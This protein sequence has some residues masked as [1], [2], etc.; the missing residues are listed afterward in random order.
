MLALSAQEILVFSGALRQA[1]HDKLYERTTGLPTKVWF[2]NDV[3]YGSL[4][5]LSELFHH[6][7]RNG[8]QFVHRD[9]YLVRSLWMCG[10]YGSVSM[11][12]PHISELDRGV[13]RL[14]RE[15]ADASGQLETLLAAVGVRDGDITD[16][17]VQPD[18]LFLVLEAAAG[19]WGVRLRDMKSVLTIEPEG[20]VGTEIGK[21][22]GF[23][24]FC[25]VI[26]DERD[27][28]PISGRSLVDAAAMAKF[29]QLVRQWNVNQNSS[30]HRFYS[31]TRDLQ[32]LLHR[33]TSAIHFL[34]RPVVV[35]LGYR[36]MSIDLAPALCSSEYMIVRAVFPSLS[37]EPRGVKEIVPPVADVDVE[38]IKA[39][40]DEIEPVIGELSKPD[41]L[42]R[43]LKE[44]DKVRIGKLSGAQ[45]LG[46]LRAVVTC[47]SIWRSAVSPAKQ[48][49]EDVY[50]RLRQPEQLA[51]VEKASS[52]LQS[53][54]PNRVKGLWTE[55]RDWSQLFEGVDAVLSSLNVL[56]EDLGTSSGGQLFDP[57]Y[58]CGTFLIAGRLRDASSEVVAQFEHLLRSEKTHWLDGVMSL[59]ATEEVS[60]DGSSQELLRY[61]LLYALRGTRLARAATTAWLGRHRDLS[62][63]PVVEA[64]FLH[65]ACL[66]RE[67]LRGMTM[68]RLTSH[69]EMSIKWIRSRSNSPVDQA[70][71]L[72]ASCTVF[73]E[74]VW[75]YQY[76]L[77]DME[78]LERHIEWWRTTTVRAAEL[79][80]ENKEASVVA[81]ALL[82]VVAGMSGGDK[83]LFD[84]GDELYQ[85]GHALSN[86]R[87][88]K[89]WRNFGFMLVEEMV[90][91]DRRREGQGYLPHWE[92]PLLI[93][94]LD[95]FKRAR[96][97]VMT[98]FEKWYV[99]E[100]GRKLSRHS[101]R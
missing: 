72:I 83:K 73:W 7:S 92:V 80:A 40:T 89:S 39:F 56:R 23:R 57:W 13:R 41:A 96:P 25:N 68:D 38:S 95:D 18:L 86:V 33:S 65:M 42:G 47:E 49:L 22:F 55:V 52:L 51:A 77:R 14:D 2:D 90:A 63:S 1:A 19:D 54:N 24:E 4:T 66:A 98:S 28:H 78:R 64:E 5:A 3:V 76:D 61:I 6:H 45:L 26:A 82:C 53:N 8:L 9:D 44:L 50:R 17:L 15:N 87:L 27:E 97:G 88:L 16:A 70:W 48:R 79:S 35:K 94:H 10:Y 29:A 36:E 69:T 37:F 84:R 60:Q 101:S 11:L 43:V 99:E 93:M 67:D 85:S 58:D 81:G 34:Q 91:K 62:M 21:I 59:L 32:S 30:M 31:H 74:W 20:S 100:L 46:E 71:I 75:E 12:A